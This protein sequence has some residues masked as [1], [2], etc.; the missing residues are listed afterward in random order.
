VIARL[1][2]MPVRA[3]LAGAAAVALLAGVAAL[4]GGHAG[5]E[6]ETLVGVW[7]NRIAQAV[8]DPP[9]LAGWRLFAVAFVGGLAA[10]LSPCILGMLPINLS[11]I[12]AAGIGSK[13]RAA[14]VAGAFIAGVVV[15]NVAIGL[16]S[17]LFFSIVVTYRAPINIA[18]G[19]VMMLMGLWLG[20]VIRLRTPQFFT[21]M[22][23][24]AGPFVV[25]LVFALIASP[26]ASPVL[27]AVLAIAT[28][29][30]SPVR[31]VAAKAF[32]AVGYTA[33]LFA[34]SLFAGVALASRRLLRYGE[35]LTRA[36]ALM[37]VVFAAFT[38]AYGWHLR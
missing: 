16:V 23:A 19:A 24:G 17:S 30:G 5:E 28:R 27:V 20:G 21:R 1:A 31:A 38:L 25:G 13:L 12:G 37:L 9:A 22:P 34:A 2:R 26:C 7:Q 14:V 18:V 4:V 8:A 33:V 11:Y 15:V 29:D 10:S 32:Y 3:A 36:G 6:L 35:T